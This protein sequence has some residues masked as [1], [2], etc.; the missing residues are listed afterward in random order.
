M[1]RTLSRDDLRE[2][3]EKALQKLE[4]YIDSLIN[5]P[6]PKIQSKADK[7]SYW[8]EDWSKFLSFEPEFHSDS[9]RRY[10]RGEIIKAHL[11]I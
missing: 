6:D 7:L 4:D 8:L 3:K 2:H 5:N 1:G 10:K 9:L 11:W